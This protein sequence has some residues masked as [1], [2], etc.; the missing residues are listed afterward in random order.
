MPRPNAAQIAYGSATVVCSAIAMLLLSGVPTGA[1][2]VVIGVAAL[3]LGLLVALTVPLP[4]RARAARE[5]SSA[6]FTALE[7]TAAESA[8]GAMAARPS[9]VRPSRLHPG[10]GAGIAH[11]G[12]HSVRR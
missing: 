5:A 1:G 8:E 6:A 2:I 9:R 11:V 4:R 3:A 7:E 10:A 12:Q